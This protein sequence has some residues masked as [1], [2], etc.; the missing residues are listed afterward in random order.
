MGD[1]YDKTNVPGTGATLSSS[2]IRAEFALIDTAINKLPDLAGNGGTLLAINAGGTAVESVGTIT[3]TSTTS[4]AFKIVAD[5]ITTGG[6]INLTSDSSS[7]STR[8]LLNVLNDNTSATGV[9]V[10]KAKQ[11]ANSVN[12]EFQNEGTSNN[13]LL[14]Q[15]GNGTALFIDTEATTANTFNISAI[16]VTTGEIISCVDANALTTGKMLRLIS[17][18]ADTSS[19]ELVRI[20][21]DNTLAT[22]ARSLYLQQDSTAD[23]Q[24]IDQNGDGIALNID[25]EAT[26]ADGINISVSSMTTGNCINIADANGLTTGSILNL[27]SNSSSTSTRNLV[28]IVNDNTLAT[29]TKCLKITQDSTGNGIYIDQNGN[30]I[31]LNIDTEATTSNTIVASAT[32]ITTGNIIACTDADALTTGSIIKLTSNSSNTSARGLLDIHNDHASSTQA[33]CIKITQDGSGRGIDITSSGV[34]VVITG[35]AASVSSMAITS[36]TQTTGSVVDILV[37]DSLTSG[38]ILDLQSDSSSTSTRN[39]VNIVNNNT[40][41]VAATCIG[42]QQDANAAFLKFS[43]DTGAD[44]S[45]AI[46]TLTT[47]GTD[48]GFVQ[49]NISG[50]KRWMKIYGDPS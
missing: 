33:H 25:T 8:T 17:D 2:T 10:I 5:S 19:R 3:S 1:W 22:G 36:S 7:S 31:A 23:G 11:D 20:A 38:S 12:V 40:A 35:Q 30:G 21:N 18:S 26:T 29:G 6:I 15:N 32:T 42:M 24:F 50:T 41:A 45:S 37:A 4:D 44:A 14:D 16:A 46:S 34:G 39:L 13:L 49:V 43:G 9:T 28:S 27:S 48:Q 47:D